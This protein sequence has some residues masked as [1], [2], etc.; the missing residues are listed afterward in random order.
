MQNLIPRN[1][2][3]FIRNLNTVIKSINIDK[4]DPL[5][6]HQRIVH[7][8][9]LE[10]PHIRG[11]LAYQ[12]MGS[13]K[14]ILAAS[15]INTVIEK[16]MFR[17]V[18]FISSKTL[19]GNF[20]GD[21]KKY[22]K[23]INHSTINS[24][25]KM[26]EY[27]L[28][29]CDFITLTAN[30]MLQQVYKAINIESD[31]LS[32][33]SNKLL[34]TNIGSIFIAI[35]E[36]HNF[37]NGIANGSKNYIGLYDLI[38]TT[39][40]IKLLFLT[41]SPIT[42]DPFEIALCFNMLNGYF[43]IES[44]K[45]KKEK[46]LTL[47]GEMYTEFNKYFVNNPTTDSEDSL[48]NKE[49]AISS[50]KNS[51]KFSNRIIGLVSYY[52]TDRAATEDLF[53]KLF[54]PIVERVSMSSE[55]YAGYA[56][57]RDKELEESQKNI[58]RQTK[59]NPLQKPQGA[60]SSYRVRSRQISNFLFPDYAINTYRDEH[61]YIKQEKF[62]EK[63]KPE[64]FELPLLEKLSPKFL[65]M[66]FNISSHLPDG[67]LDSFKKTKKTSAIGPGI[68]YSQFI[69]SGIGLLAKILEHHGM[70][71][72]KTIND[73]NSQLNDTNKKGTFI[74][75]SG[76]VNAELRTELIKITKSEDNKKGELLSL[77]LI[78]S[79]G[80]EGISTKFMR[81]VHV[82]DPYW[83]WAR[84]A[85]VFARAARLGSHIELPK[86]ERNVQPYIYLSDYPKSSISNLKI[87]ETTDVS[88]YHKSLQN[89]ILI[90]SFLKVIKESS[91]DCLIHYND[92]KVKCRICNPTD[93]IL[94]LNDLDSDMKNP[95]KCQPL[96]EEK[97][98]A[99]SISIEDENG[100]R[101]YMYYISNDNLH[102][103]RKNDDIDAYQEIYTDHP[104][105]FE[106]SEKI[107]K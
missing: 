18:L 12:E 51:D 21:F 49:Q 28:N 68:V 2:T 64:C 7:E 14:T 77:L 78:S 99:K 26:E 63:L 29:N 87:E 57:A 47:F 42:N 76:E 56:A 9:L 72:I 53:P 38:M 10:Y 36:A 98:K 105:Y 15:I 46:K 92:E 50:I 84:I 17:K 48:D 4:K 31:I 70:F 8:Y 102:I 61:G 52:G 65:K 25:E 54:D 24:D 11:I 62:I 55:Q 34:N 83:N 39:K 66:L 32:D 85:Q 27:I 89:Q 79:T 41:G 100:K 82:I 97:I 37:F 101:D 23:M 13:G 106:L 91:M 81:H 6:Y 93:Q 20:L 1:N 103:F 22:L 94:F 19:H 80:A 45:F 74:I 43:H 44:D 104:D 30:N 90:D 3:S 75:I 73:L 88:L 67:I 107:L 35:D 95:S 59:S 69:V 60:S 40:N 16:Q 58:F 96:I 33:P 86:E 5:K 71:Q